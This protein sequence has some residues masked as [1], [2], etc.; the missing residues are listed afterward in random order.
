MK[1]F[2]SRFANQVWPPDS[3]DRIQARI[4]ELLNWRF[5]FSSGE[6]FIFLRLAFSSLG[7]LHVVELA[8]GSR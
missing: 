5:L 3:G 2:N 4:L 8:R 1:A 6:Y 7:K